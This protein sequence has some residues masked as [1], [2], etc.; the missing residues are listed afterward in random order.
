MLIGDLPS[1]Q[2]AAGLPSCYVRFGSKADTIACPRDVRLPSESGHVQCTTPCLLWAISG[3]MHRSKKDCYSITSSVRASKLYGIVRPSA[4]AV[5]RLTI[6]SNLVARSTGR[7]LGF[8]PFRILSTN[9][10]ARR[11]MS[12]VSTP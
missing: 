1:R 10:A 9:V 5:F 8:A 2:G 6:V 4:L 12:R 3:L 11:N 7:S